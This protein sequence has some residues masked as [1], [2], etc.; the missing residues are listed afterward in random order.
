MQKT[1]SGEKSI[2]ELF[3]KKGSSSGQFRQKETFKIGP[4][5]KNEEDKIV[6]YRIRANNTYRPYKKEEMFHIPFEKRGLVSNQRY[7]VSGYP[8]LYLGRST[9]G[10]WEATGRPDAEK[11]NVVALKA[12]KKFN[13]FDLR[14]PMTPFHHDELYADDLYDLVLPLACSLRCLNVSD[15]FKPEYIIPQRILNLIIEGD[16][17]GVDGIIYTSNVY[18]QEDNLFKNKEDRYEYMELFDNIVIPIKRS[19][20]EGLCEDLV[21]GFTM[22][23]PTSMLKEELT[24]DI[25]LPSSPDPGWNIYE[26]TKWGELERKLKSGKFGPI[27]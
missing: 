22:T 26:R 1:A 10:C 21:K 23:E 14:A 11:F 8:C 7:S 16:D 9:Y 12:A 15:P 2:E 4:G 24:R 18:Y 19:N 25:T 17:L 20:K 27:E 13:L 6:F 5:D 3:F